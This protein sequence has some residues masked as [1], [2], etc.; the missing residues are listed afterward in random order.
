[1]FTSLVVHPRG[2]ARRAFDWDDVERKFVRLT[3]GVIGEKK[4]RG[5]VSE[6]RRANRQAAIPE[7]WDLR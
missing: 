7:L 5:V 1:M 3:G 4:A 6:T 2:D